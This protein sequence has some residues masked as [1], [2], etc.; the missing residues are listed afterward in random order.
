MILKFKLNEQLLTEDIASVKKNYPKIDDETFDTLIRL[1]PTFNE[2]KNSVGTYGKWILNLYNKG[3]LKEEDFYKVTDYLTDFEANKKN[4]KNKDIGQFKTLPDLSRAL[5][6]VVPAE[7]SH[8]QQ[9]RQNQKARKNADLGNEASLVYED[10]KWEVW[11][12]HTYAAS[13]K[14]GEGSS[15]CTA[16]TESD[17]Y[18]NYY[19]NYYGGEYYININKSNPDE[20]YQF[21]FESNQYMDIDDGMINLGDFLHENEGLKE[22]YRPIILK[23]INGSNEFEQ[24]ENGYYSINFETSDRTIKDCA[25]DALEKYQARFVKDI[26]S[27]ATV[28]TFG[29]YDYDYL[30]YSD[31]DIYSDLYDYL[32]NSANIKSYLEDNDVYSFEDFEDFADNDDDIQKALVRASISAYEM[33]ASIEIEKQYY[34]ALKECNIYPISNYYG[35]GASF[36]FSYDDILDILS[37]VDDEIDFSVDGLI[38]AEFKANKDDFDE[39]Y[40]GW[41]EFDDDTFK[42]EAVFQI[43]EII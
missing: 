16:T 31:I 38:T 28:D 6:D 34:R 35:D 14:L 27:G 43:E 13:C 7:L 42:E 2:N 41:N 39:P 15:W 22:F 9:V 29:I 24:D 4:F 37:D 19:K 8:R 25:D 32:L 17:H 23:L 12:P 5:R 20:K 18:Y 40:Y 36:R 30:D 26:L 11:V 33:G 21:H 3:N 1:D 10:S